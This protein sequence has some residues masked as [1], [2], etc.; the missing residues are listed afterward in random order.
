[1]SSIATEL[2]TA[3]EYALLPDTGEPTE[4]VQGRIVPMN[5]PSSNHGY[6]CVEIASIL[7]NFVK[8]NG[9]GRI[10]GND[11][12]VVTEHNPDTVRG[13]DIAFY[14]FQRMPA[15]ET[16]EGYW[17][18]APDLVIEVRSASDRWRQILSKVGEYLNAGVSIVAVADPE[19]RSVH[20]FHSDRPSEVLKADMLL[21]FPEVL[22]GFEI[23]V[24][25]LFE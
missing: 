25:N 21:T 23:A 4:L 20:L 7:R 16:P 22:P 12:G 9:L 2:L 6:H 5:R 19:M 17:P 8:T 18:V 24:G 13:P 10:V 14:S 11:S 3:E 1:M 15:G